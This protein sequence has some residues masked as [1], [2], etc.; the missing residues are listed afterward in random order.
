MAKIIPNSLAKEEIVRYPSN[1]RIIL[2]TV[3]IQVGD[4]IWVGGVGGGTRIGRFQAP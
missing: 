2:G 1:D 3:G 4:E